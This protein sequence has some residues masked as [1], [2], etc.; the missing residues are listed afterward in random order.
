MDKIMRNVEAISHSTITL[1]RCAETLLHSSFAPIS[2]AD[3]VV[4]VDV[5]G[6][7]MDVYV[8][9]RPW[10]RYFLQQLSFYFE[11]VVFTASLPR[12]ADSVLDYIDTSS[13]IHSRLYR[14]SCVLHDGCYVKDLTRLGRPIER[15]AI[16]DNSAHSYMFQPTNAIPSINYIDDPFDNGLLY[17]LDVLLRVKDAHDIRLA[18][19]GARVAAQYMTESHMT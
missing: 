1:Y 13:T 4:P 14:E 9:T 7:T 8:T 17:I 5:D 15:V 18:L 10:L 3:F 19:P 6:V 16:V 2:N 11:V 12:Y